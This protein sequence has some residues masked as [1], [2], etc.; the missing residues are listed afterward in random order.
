[1]FTTPLSII[2]SSTFAWLVVKYLPSSMALFWLAV[3]MCIDLIT[4]LLKAWHRKMCSTSRGFKRTVTK[5]LSYSATIVV[6]VVLVNI[7]GV[8]D[9]EN[10]YD[11]SVLINLLLGFM[12]FI[13]LFSICENIQVAYP[14]SPLNQYLIKYIMKFLKGRLKQNPFPDNK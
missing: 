14:N 7:L 11:L 5:I 1:M 12:T 2:L 13:E 3:A 4:G 9:S 6:V 10:K 8:V